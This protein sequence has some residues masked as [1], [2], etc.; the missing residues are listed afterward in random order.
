M[1]TLLP[2]TSRITNALTNAETFGALSTPPVEAVSGFYTVNINQF[3]R[4]LQP[5]I[6]R[7]TI[8][9]PTETDVTIGTIDGPTVLV[10]AGGTVTVSPDGEPVYLHGSSEENA[11]LY[12]DAAR[13]TAGTL[14]PVLEDV[15]EVATSVNSGVNIDFFANELVLVDDSASDQFRAFSLDDFSSA[16]TYDPSTAAGIDFQQH[17]PDSVRKGSW[18]IGEDR[19]TN[20]LVQINPKTG[21][22]NVLTTLADEL[23]FPPRGFT[24]PGFTGY[25]CMLNTGGTNVFAFDTDGNTVD[26][27]DITAPTMAGEEE[28]VPELFSSGRFFAITTLGVGTTLATYDFVDNLWREYTQPAGFSNNPVLGTTDFYI[29]SDDDVH[30][31]LAVNAATFSEVKRFDL[32]IGTPDGAFNRERWKNYKITVGERDF[33]FLTQTE[34]IFQTNFGFIGDTILP[35]GALGTV[36]GNELTLR[37]RLDGRTIGTVAQQTGAGIDSFAY[38][39]EPRRETLAWRGTDST[40]YAGRLRFKWNPTGNLA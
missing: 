14:T 34:E 36:S 3:K 37:D 18:Y 13:S 26:S 31:L 29:D 1:A 15:T 21:D 25:L 5:D 40:V 16:Y 38:G 12:I 8:H 23:D 7:A 28:R 11:V 2:N 10:E 33:W 22:V 24:R 39:Y 9:N 19:N 35:L 20:D 30:T 17:A 6:V 32:P 4:I 27:A